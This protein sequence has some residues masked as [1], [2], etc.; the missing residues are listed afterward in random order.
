MWALLGAAQLARST[1]FYHLK[2]LRLPD[3]QAELKNQIHQIYDEHNGRYG[4]RRITAT[5]CRSGS[6]V[7]H[8][9]IQRLMQ[10]MGLRSRVRPKKYRSYKGQIGRIADNLL[11]RQFGAEKPNCKWVTDVTEFKVG[12]EK[13]YL[14]PLMDLFN[15]EIISYQLARRPAFA[16][17]GK[18]LEEALAKLTP[19]QKPMIHSDQG[20]QYQMEHYQSQL[21][22]N[23]L[24]QSMSRKANCLDNACMESFFAT[25][26]SE[27]FYIE[28][29]E[30][31]EQL[32]Q[33]V[34]KYIHYYNHKRIKLKSKGLS[35]VQY[36]IQSFNPT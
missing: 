21:A 6:W 36:R 1:F 20:W 24:T 18:M 12:S 11:Q 34:H 13:L 4:Y 27:C 32:E 15:G 8:K 5:I 29:F 19:D 33:Q 10:Q 17:V 3:P 9:R 7:N 31:I 25:L 35:S 16:L 23:G 2:R 14:S 30:S 26:K 28:Q 22:Q